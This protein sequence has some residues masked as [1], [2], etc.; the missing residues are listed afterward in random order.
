M[1]VW[2]FSF[3]AGNYGA[4]QMEKFSKTVEASLGQPIN[5]FWFVAAITAVATLCLF[6]L[7]PWLSKMM[8]GIN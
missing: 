1:G 5:V 7:G 6:A 8:K 4:S 3:A 2:M